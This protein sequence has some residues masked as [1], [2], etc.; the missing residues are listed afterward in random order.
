MV[1]EVAFRTPEFAGW[2]TEPWF[3]HCEHA[4]EFLGPMGRPE[5]DAVGLRRQKSSARRPAIRTKNGRN[6]TKP[7]TG[8]MDPP[9]ISFDAATV[10]NCVAILTAT[11]RLPFI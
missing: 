10:G 8:S 2:Q 9:L 5:L 4:G 11:S 3:T 1:E 7:A 6:P